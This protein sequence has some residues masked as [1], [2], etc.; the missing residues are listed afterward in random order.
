MYVRSRAP[1]LPGPD[2]R[3]LARTSPHERDARIRFDEEAHAY[4]VYDAASET[5]LR[6]ERSV[7]GL[8]KVLMP[9][10]FDAEAQS[11]RLAKRVRYDK[12]SPYYWLA[13]SLADESEAACASA[14]REAWARSGARSSGY[15]TFCHLQL[16]RA[17]NGERL[18]E[19]ERTPHV[20]AG[21]EW[22]RARQDEDGWEPYRTEWSIFIDMRAEAEALTAGEGAATEDAA[23][24]LPRQ[25]CVLCGQLDALFVD[26]R[27]DYH[28]VDWKFTQ[29]DKL[30]K[31]NGAQFAP[32]GRVP[33]GAWPLDD[34]PNNSYGHYLFQQ[35][36]YAHILAQR[37]G[38]RVKTSRLLHIPVVSRD[39]EG[40]VRA[41]EVP[42]ELLGTAAVRE[43]FAAAMKRF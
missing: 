38:I 18:S 29:P 27:G 32:G 22:I 24:L 5:H 3:A 33:T 10:T 16:E 28:L 1:A 43:A 23:H 20:A 15:G 19:K 11:L 2:T 41:R 21:L 9:E 30:D 8:I 42:L 7:S 6:I 26:D 37:Y 25:D 34:V 13:H 40:P 35:S 12:R 14:I 4:Y 39:E 36:T 17:L 31:D